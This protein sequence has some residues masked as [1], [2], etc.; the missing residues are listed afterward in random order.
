MCSKSAFRLCFD[1]LNMT[2]NCQPELVEGV[3]SKRVL[4]G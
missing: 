1:R 4:K 3:E 2:E